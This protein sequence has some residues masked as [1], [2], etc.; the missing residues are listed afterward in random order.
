MTGPLRIEILGPL[1]VLHQGAPI[2][3]GPHRLQALLAVLA[4]RANLVCTP[5]DLLDLVWHDNPPG[6]GLKVLPP[7]IYRLRRALPEDVVHRT[8]NGYILRLPADALDITE[9]EAIA[10]HASQLRD[11][12]ELDA[13][14]S[15]YSQALALFRG[16]P[17]TGLPGQY[18]A[19]QRTRLIERRDKVFA[20]RLDVELHRGNGADLIAE[21]VPAVAAR[22]F[23]ERLAGQLMQALAA[24]GRQAE[25]LDLYTA[26]RQT[27]I[28][29][30]GVE[31]GHNLR[32]IHR[33]VLRS[34]SAAGTRDELPYAG[35]VFVGRTAELDRLTSALGSRSTSAP[36]VVAI[37]GMAGA[38]KTALALHAARR[39]ADQ[40]PDGLLFADLH[41]HTSG[42]RPRDVKS[43]LDHLLAGAGVTA[44]AIPPGLEEAQALWRTT[45]AGRHL[46]IVLDNAWDS[47]AVTPLLPGSPTCSVVITSRAQLTG[48]D[49]RERMHLG[50]LTQVDATALLT[51]LVGSE[52]ASTDVAASNGLIER[53]GNLPLA[54]RI[55]CARLRYRPL[56]TV[57]HINDRLD[58]V[59]R[60][61]PELSADGLAVSAAFELS[62]EQLPPDQQRFF[63]L[64]GL[65]PGADLDQYGAAALTGLD[66]SEASDLAESLVDA[67]LL[68]QHSPGRYEFHDLLREYAQRLAVDADAPSLRNAATDRLLE[69]YLQASFHSFATEEGQRYFDPGLRT[70]HAVPRHAT[71]KEAKAWGDAEADNLGAAVE[72]AATTDDHTRTWQLALAV[73]GYLERRG[74]IQ[75][76]DRILA[77]GL[78]AA[79]TLGDKEVQARVLLATGA[80]N[81]SRRGVQFAAEKLRLA[82]E[83]LPADGDLLLRGLLHSALGASLRHLDPLGEALT[84]LQEATRIG[85]ELKHELL[86]AQS[87]SNT[88]M[89]YTNAPDHA[90][91]VVAYVE[92]IEILNR[93]QRGGMMSEALS[94]LTNSY[95]ALGRIQ[96]AVVTATAAYDLSVELGN[97]ISLPWALGALGSA[98]RANGDLERA[99]AIHRQAVAAAAEVKMVLATWS[100][101]QSLGESLLAIGDTDGAFACYQPVLTESMAAKDYI[102]VVE[103][104]D[105]LADHALAVADREA[106]VGYLTQGLAVADEHTPSRSPGLRERLAALTG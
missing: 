35:A 102:Y 7:Y 71:L 2:T 14:A 65:V 66:P 62:Y 45:V 91:A 97:K 81:R 88:G 55:A 6:T 101:Q 89:L 76:Q 64:L 59:G 36:P 98:H 11:R 25:A 96:D 33:S 52:R 16:E 40:Y 22:P 28:D 90:A 60:R 29:Q 56:W 104:L 67:N 105:L 82:L 85:R 18:L 50:L 72:Y 1:R 26:T 57:A 78:A 75:Q 95:L 21:L 34:E 20:D 37:D 46:L 44:T 24:D 19:T 27:L 17:L 9:F 73:V 47:S 48:L 58:Q 69:Y 30:L 42:R 99:V 3:V 86:I 53:C 103:S 49:V 32:E 77:I 92:A 61:L 74:K 63:R 13:A 51:R 31:P 106:A 43:A 41:G 100:M 87:L 38:G 54:L 39:L 70:A 79:E 8:S 68:L 5:E 93:I 4:L 80:L 15:A 83:T 12:G 23:D 94:G 10:E 84:N